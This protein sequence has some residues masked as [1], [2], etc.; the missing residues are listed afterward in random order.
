MRLVLLRHAL[1]MLAA[2]ALLILLVFTSDLTL[3][4]VNRVLAELTWWH[5]AGFAS[6]TIALL[7]L[8]AVKW[9]LV[10]GELQDVDETMLSLR[11]AFF[12]TCIGATLSLVLMPHAAMP[13]GR[14]LGARLYG[15]LPV[16]RSFS[17]SILEQVFDVVVIVVF[18]A[19]GVAVLLPKALPGVAVMAFVAIAA[20]VLVAVRPTVLPQRLRATGI[21]ALFR[22][23]VPLSL[24]SISVLRYVLVA[25]RAFI[26]AAPAGIVLAPP[27][28]FASFSLV[29][30]SRIIAVTPLGLGV[31]DWTW[32]GVLSLS[33][34][35]LS[36]A[37]S[38]VLLQRSLDMLSTLIA[39]GVGALL[40]V[41]RRR[42]PA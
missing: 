21:I 13:T 6:T 8:S 38:F 20:I 4:T 40:A 11:A 3:E 23:S 26:I 18:A 29:Q 17:A 37:A 25:L 14:A 5:L 16:V 24:A 30:V 19:F 27:S 35:S 10:M 15:S 2:L 7:F 9:R 39:L 41:R 22:T 31:V 28:F 36:V 33:H 1:P 32:A 34:L 12:F 42:E